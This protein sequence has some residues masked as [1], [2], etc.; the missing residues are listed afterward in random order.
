MKTDD[1]YLRAAVRAYHKRMRPRLPHRDGKPV[2]GKVWLIEPSRRLAFPAL[3][4]VLDGPFVRP[5]PELAPLG[6]RGRKAVPDSRRARPYSPAGPKRVG[7][8]LHPREMSYSVDLPVIAFALV[9]PGDVFG[10]SALVRGLYR[11]GKRPGYLRDDLPAVPLRGV[12]DYPTAKWAQVTV[13]P[14]RVLRPSYKCNGL[15]ERPEMT[16]GWLL[17]CVSQAYV[18]V[19]QRHD[20][21]GV[22]GHDLSDLCFSDVRIVDGAF[23]IIV[24]S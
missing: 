5:A 11:T 17:W 8:L 9:P 20:E 3:P 18:E 10:A 14:C 16:L 22:Y 15:A 6:V 1:P 13:R 19:Y 2:F 7:D 21:F 12:I 23:E 4:F 24:S